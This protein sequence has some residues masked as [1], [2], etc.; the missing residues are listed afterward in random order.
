MAGLTTERA[1]VFIGFMGA[2]K[3][4]ALAAA[5]EAGLQTTEVDELLER[6]LGMP[7]DGFFEREGEQEF[8]RRE[9]ELV[10]PLLERAEGGAIALGGGSVLSER[11][12]AALQR[13]W[14]AGCRSTLLKRGAG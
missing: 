9:A 12:R 10:V 4:T 2:G 7:I 1:L 8:R 13:T 11:V 3:T 5:R 14:C 6:D